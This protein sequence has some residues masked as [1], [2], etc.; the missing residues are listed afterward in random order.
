MGHRGEGLARVG[1]KPV[2]VPFTLP[3]ERARIRYSG[4]HGRLLGVETTSPERIDP[5]CPHF[6]QCGGC[7]LQHWAPDAYAEF[8]RGLVES[9]LLRAGLDA[10]VEPM[11][12]ARGAGRRRATLHVRG[13]SVGFN[14]PR[15]HRVHEIDRCPI[16]VPG[17]AG[18][19]AIA[20]AIAKAAGDCDIAFTETLFGI[21]AAISGAQ[22]DD[23]LKLGRIAA[24]FD[25]ARLSLDGEEVLVPRP[26]EIMV[27][28]ARV[29][30]PPGAFLQATA[31][32]ETILAELVTKAVD[33]ALRVAD[34]FCGIGTFALRLAEKAQVLASDA[35]KRA[36]LALNSAAQHTQGLKTVRADTRDLFHEPVSAREL[37]GYEAV[38]MDPPRAGAAAQSRELAQSDVPLVVSVSCDPASFARDAR[39]L[40]DGGYRLDPVV[41]V[42][43]FAYSAHV[44]VVGIFRR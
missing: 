43:Q 42:D 8:K 34:L 38:V 5:I 44:E 26:P 3:G 2:Y 17:L 23:L 31:E 9:A 11:V 18:A 22:R 25:L 6:G 40:A 32:A 12:D 41:P 24:E 33:G 16:L 1:D 36:V 37:S 29:R 27:G 21:D 10:Q 35:D 15:S 28:K 19:P 7:Q 39:I 14:A 20:R 4:Q 13:K 30:L